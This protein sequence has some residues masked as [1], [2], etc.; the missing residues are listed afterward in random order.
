MNE[1]AFDRVP[2]QDLEAERSVLGGMM[3]NKDAIADVLEVLQG[4]DFYRPA[5]TS[6]YAVILDLF[7]RGEPADAVTVSAELQRRGEL[8][9]IGG[10]TYIF[11]L[12]NGVPTAANTGYYAHIVREQAQLRSLIEVGTRITQ[13]GYTTDGADVAELLNTAQSE[14]FQ[15][16]ESRTK[17]DYASFHDIVPGLIEELEINA[18]RDGAVS[19][20]ATGF[21]DLDGVL[22][23][24]RPGQMVIVAARPGMGKTTIAMDFCRHIAF[25]EHKPVAFFSLEMGRTELAMRVLAAEGE[26]PLSAL[27]S[28]DIRQN[29][30]ERISKT[31][32]RIAEGPL[33]VDDSPNLTMMEIRAKSRRM[34]QQHG[35][36]LIVID[37]LQLLTSGGRTPESR[38][39][40]VSEFSRSIK[41]LAKEL[42]VPIIA[43]A[44]LNRNPEQRN[45]K[46]PQV[47]DLR[48]SGSLEQDADVVMLINRP[49]AEDGSLDMPPAEVIVGKNRSG[50]TAK[51][52][53]AFQGNY[54]RFASFGGE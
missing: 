17:N 35:I 12:V 47:S 24:L 6:I 40:E 22:N 33:Y 2:P 10:R 31:L 3:I 19:G 41:L 43:I 25:R 37:Y 34:R 49:Q 7:S 28:G 51:I 13:L 29:Q 8:D 16:T 9:R 53:L 46:T 1:V 39:Q 50:P 32:A 21:H 20:L 48:E 36:E 5:H 23:G 15:M 54:T 45:D 52:E 11:D 42:D 18:S 14:V 44:Q 30:W 27:I 26:I 4:E 38:Q